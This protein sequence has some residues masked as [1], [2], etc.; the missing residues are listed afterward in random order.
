MGPVEEGPVNCGPVCSI[1]QSLKV[2]AVVYVISCYMLKCGVAFC[3]RSSKQAEFTGIQP[4]AS[5]QLQR[6]NQ[7]VM[8]KWSIQQWLNLPS[9]AQEAHSVLTHILEVR[10]GRRLYRQAGHRLFRFLCLFHTTGIGH[11]WPNT[12]SNLLCQRN[13]QGFG[14]DKI[15]SSCSPAASRLRLFFKYEQ[16]TLKW[17]ISFLFLNFLFIFITESTIY[18]PSFP[19]LTSCS[20]PSPQAFSTHGFVCAHG[21]CVQYRYTRS[22]VDHHSPSHPPPPPL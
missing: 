10:G 19:P 20:L 14:V 18:V 2:W 13:Q 12:T 6:G 11:S 3:R 17:R 16:T 7:H 4:D 9:P 21:L 22:L 1:G 5:S 8:S 15:C